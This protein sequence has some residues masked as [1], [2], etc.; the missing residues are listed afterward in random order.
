MW[1]STKPMPAPDMYSN[2]TSAAGSSACNRPSSAVAARTEASAHS[3]TSRSRGRGA[4]FSTAAVMIPSVPSLPTNSWRRQY[5][6]LSLRSRRSPSHTVPSGSTT[7]SP[8]TRSRALP[9][10]TVELPPALVASTPPICAVPSELMDSGSSRSAASA[11]SCA[12]FS[13]TPASTVMVMS[14]ASISRTRFSRDRLSTSCDPSSE[15]T[16][17]PTMEVLP[18]CGTTA[19][20]SRAHSAST[21]A[22]SAVSAGRTTAGVRPWYSRRQSSQKGA[23]SAPVSSPRSPTRA[24]RRSSSAGGGRVSGIP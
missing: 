12:A 6:V 3:A 10:R 18:P 23:A 22:T 15:G 20:P 9:K 1:R 7:S 4:S 21:A 14:S 19:T 2:A 24:C 16:A 17:P 8:S 11:A 5:P 13:V